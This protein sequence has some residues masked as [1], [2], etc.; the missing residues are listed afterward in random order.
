MLV[1]QA[2]VGKDIVDCLLVAPSCQ[3]CKFPNVFVPYHTE[4]PESPAIRMFMVCMSISMVHDGDGQ[5]GNEG[6][7][8]ALGWMG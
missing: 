4:L 3:L 7:G 5:R 8:L 6:F 2:E 1:K